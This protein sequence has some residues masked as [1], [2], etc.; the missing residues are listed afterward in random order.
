MGIV[1]GDGVN[2]RPNSSLTRQ[3]AMVMIK[4]ALTA[5]G[6]NLGNGSSVDLSRFVDSREVASYAR[7]AVGTLVRLGAVNGDNRGRL[8]PRSDITR[9]EIAV[10]LHFVMTM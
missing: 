8:N 4:N 6:W 9:A 7:D 10:I 1:N 3:D 5:A 2:F